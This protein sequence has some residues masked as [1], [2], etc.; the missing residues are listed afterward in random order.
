MVWVGLEQRSGQ[1]E[2]WFPMH[3]RSE[4]QKAILDFD[5]ISKVSLSDVL[6]RE[7]TRAYIISAPPAMV[8][9]HLEIFS[10]LSGAG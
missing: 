8:E 1:R 6:G 7:S 2:A 5:L 10:T 9:L 4:L 3:S